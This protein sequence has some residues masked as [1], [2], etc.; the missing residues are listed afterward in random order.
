MRR[1]AN[2]DTNVSFQ[3]RTK[4][5]S[6]SK[7]FSLSTNRS[8]RRFEIRISLKIYRRRQRQTARKHLPPPPSLTPPAALKFKRVRCC[9]PHTRA[10]LTS[11]APT[12]LLSSPS[13]LRQR[14]DGDGSKPGLLV[15]SARSRRLRQVW[16]P[17]AGGGVIAVINL[18][19][20]LSYVWMTRDGG[21]SQHREMTLSLGFCI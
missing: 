14:S 8:V 2:V 7:Q 15:Y 20:I 13:L 1:E 5:I 19:R 6:A 3:P 9:K 4:R 18:S 16:E 10:L 21:F 12:T 11:T 17:H